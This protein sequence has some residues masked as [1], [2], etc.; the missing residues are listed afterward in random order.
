MVIANGHVE[1]SDY[2]KLAVSS[3]I[4][5]KRLNHEITKI[6][7]IVSVTMN[8]NKL[9]HDINHFLLPYFIHVT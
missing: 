9:F 8:I 5:T 7:F 1:Y 2:L 6:F 3:R 4:V